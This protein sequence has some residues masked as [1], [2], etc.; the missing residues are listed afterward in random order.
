AGHGRS[1]N[2]KLGPQMALGIDAR[3]R[4]EVLARELGVDPQTFSQ[5]LLER[6]LAEALS[7]LDPQARERV[8]AELHTRLLSELEA[9]RER[10]RFEG[11][12]P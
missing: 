8:N 4:L 12:A 2:G 6:A 10:V 7:C 5:Q 9:E 1:R 11:G 3:R